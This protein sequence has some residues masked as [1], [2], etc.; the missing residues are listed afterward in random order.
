VPEVQ[1]VL[2]AAVRGR[3]ADCRKAPS[4]RAAATILHTPPSGEAPL[5][6]T[7]NR[8]HWAASDDIDGPGKRRALGPSVHA[9]LTPSGLHAGGTA[10]GSHHAGLG[11]PT[12]MTYNWP[13]WLEAGLV[14]CGIRF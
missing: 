12:A 1:S 3:R 10:G 9:G 2:A 6:L 13:P 8:R 4:T 11:S 7:K 14:E 5:Q